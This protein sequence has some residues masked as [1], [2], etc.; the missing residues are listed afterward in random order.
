MLLLLGALGFDSAGFAAAGF[1]L[2]AFVSETFASD[3]ADFDSDVE[4]SLDFD[5]LD[6]LASPEELESPPPVPLS[7]DADPPSPFDPDLRA[8]FWSFFPSFP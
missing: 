3:F 7:D 2:E 8:A 5:S 1:A 6:D 4:E